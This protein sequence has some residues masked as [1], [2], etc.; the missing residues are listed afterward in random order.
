LVQTIKNVFRI[1]DLRKKIL[2][3][4]VCLILFRLGSFIP[5]PGVNTRMLANLFNTP[6]GNL[7]D[8]FNLFSGGNFARASIFA[9]GIM[10]YITASIVMQLLGGVVPFIEKLKKEGPEGHKKINQLTRYFTV[11][12]GL[13]NAVGMGFF[14]L[15]PAATGVVVIDPTLFMM[16]SILSMVT[17]TIVIMWIGEQITEK[18]IGNGISLIIFAGIIAEYPPGFLEIFSLYRAGGLGIFNILVFV[19]AMLLVTSSVILI[20]E[21]T[22]RVSIQYPKKIV[23]RKTYGGQN[24]YFPMKLNQ[25][26][27]IPIIFASSVIMMPRTIA[28]FIPNSLFAE[29]MM[30][31]LS[32]GNIVYTLF[33]MGL[34]IFFSY[35][36]TA[37]AVNPTEM[38]ENMK[39]QGGYVQGVQPGK[40][41]AKYF[42]NIMTRITLPFLNL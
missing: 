32:P 28:A 39:R 2:F 41:T 9:M 11:I 3:T 40:N 31:F 4:V 27:V 13:F 42:N 33:F 37:I 24:M 22:R 7:F 10:P 23:G 25:A 38:A 15:S 26:G 6:G 30:R 8:M 5:V 34:I 18:G 20:T 35:F 12:I 19:A 17:G 29:I 21:A 36:Y 14:L 16:M 1:P